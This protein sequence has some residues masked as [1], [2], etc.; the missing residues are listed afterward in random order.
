MKKI[1]TTA[2]LAAV[3]MMS[4]QAAPD[5]G[6]T[7]IQTSKLWSIQANLRGFYDDNITTVPNAIAQDSV[8]VEITPSIGLNIQRDQ[9]Y[10]GLGYEYKL[11]WFEDRDPDNA[12]NSHRFNLD[13]TH[14]VSETTT[15]DLGDEFVIAQEPEVLE[16]TGATRL[17]SNMDAIRN[18]AHIN[19]TTQLGNTF[20]LMA[21]YRNDLYNYDQ[22]GAGSF[23]ALLDRLEHRF[24]ANLRRQLGSSQTA[25]ILGYQYRL[26]D[27]TSDDS[28]VQGSFLSPEVRNSGSHYVYA[29]L[30]HTFTTSLQGSIRAGAQF[31]S[32]DNVGPTVD[33]STASPYVDANLSYTYAEGSNISVG[34]RHERNQTDLA[35]VGGSLVL[36]QETTA[37]YASIAHQLTAKITA[38][39]VGL[40]ADSSFGDSLASNASDEFVSFGLNLGY[41]I[42]QHLLAETGYN[43]DD[44]SSDLG[45]RS[46]DRNRVY[47]GLKASY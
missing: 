23:S 2:G 4:M 24:T 47:I 19:F 3:G 32:Y 31:T 10:L 22:D 43:L 21:G 15:F 11:R 1:V 18:R 27:Y 8:G 20:A 30:D 29:G 46:Y 41:Q 7:P 34:V 28:L 33:D 39:V 38:N 16:P 44:L 25:G 17:R 14:D 35:Q 40:Y 13:L 45:N 9:T 37:V 12:D 36:D 6:L 42:N 5:V 26:V